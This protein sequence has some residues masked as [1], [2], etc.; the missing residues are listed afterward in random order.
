MNARHLLAVPAMA[1]LM[2]PFALSAQAH[3][4][5]IAN[6]EL[7]PYAAADFGINPEDVTFSRDIAPILTSGGSLKRPFRS[8]ES[9]SS[10]WSLATARC[11][12]TKTSPSL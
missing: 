6:H 4:A 2:M 11:S 5:S 9:T 7:H 3:D 12:V 1:L 10:V 8:R